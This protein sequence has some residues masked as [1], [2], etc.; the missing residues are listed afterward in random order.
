[1]DYHGKP[2]IDHIIDELKKTELPL[3]VAI[4]KGD[5][6]LFDHLI[7]KVDVFSGSEND[8]IERYYECAKKHGFDPII[9]VA[10]DAK[11]IHHEL[12]LQQLENYKKFGHM[13][14]GNYCEV[15]SMEQL[16]WHYKNDKRPQT[17]EHVTAGMIQDLTV[18]YKIDLD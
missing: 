18:D 6:D 14:Y 2:L 12:V 16:E 17:R 9:R 10:A 7:G 4:P 1:M 5:H 11:M 13:I 15:F 8:V 3:V